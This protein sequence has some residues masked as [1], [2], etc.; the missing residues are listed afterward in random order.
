MIKRFKKII[1]TIQIQNQNIDLFESIVKNY[2]ENKQKYQAQYKEK[3]IIEI[4]LYLIFIYFM[5]LYANNSI[6]I[7]MEKRRE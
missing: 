6:K 3:T 5:S 4:E 1:Q 7:Y 2:K